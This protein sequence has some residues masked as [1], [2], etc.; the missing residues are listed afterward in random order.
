M[1]HRFDRGSEGTDERL[2]HIL[3]DMHELV[4]KVVRLLER[5]QRYRVAVRDPANAA[6]HARHELRPPEAPHVEHDRIT[7]EPH[8]LRPGDERSNDADKRPWGVQDVLEGLHT[9]LRFQESLA[10][11][12]CPLRSYR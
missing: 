9:N 10:H 2:L 11:D 5:S 3:P 1:L 4:R 6:A 7:H 8:A 12:V